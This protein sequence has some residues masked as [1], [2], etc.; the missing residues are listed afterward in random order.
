MFAIVVGVGVATYGTLRLLSRDSDTPTTFASTTTAVATTVPSPDTS[1]VTTS[2]FAPTTTSTTAPP[3]TTTTLPTPPEEIT[4]EVLNST[5]RQ[6][7]AAVLTEK[8][9]AA[10]YQTN[11]PTNYEK[12]LKKSRVWYRKG[13]SAEAKI[14]AEEFVPDAIVEAFPGGIDTDAGLIVIIGASY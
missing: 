7:V 13:L 1:A 9:E 4:V 8:L 10:G 6:G 2:T 3:T 5:N 14:L 12:S 11:K